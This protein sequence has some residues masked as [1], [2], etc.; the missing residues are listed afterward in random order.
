MFKEKSG[1]H[2][3]GGDWHYQ[4]LNSIQ[5]VL[6]DGPVQNCVSCHAACAANDYLCTRR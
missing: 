6:D 2:L 1:Y 4:R 3:A 5:R